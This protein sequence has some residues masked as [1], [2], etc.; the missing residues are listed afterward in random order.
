MV[1]NNEKFI[2]KVNICYI[3]YIWY[4]LEEKIKIF[5]LWVDYN[6]YNVRLYKIW[7]IFKKY[8]IC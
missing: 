5:G 6:I 2:L 4:G 8:F 3:Y 7:K 1:Y